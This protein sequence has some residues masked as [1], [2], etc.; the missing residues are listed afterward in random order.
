ML[1]LLLN[2]SDD[3]TAIVAC[4]LTVAGAALIVFASYHL[5]PAG[6]E[7]RSRRKGISNPIAGSEIPFEATQS[8]DRAA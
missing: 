7:L 6:Q 3:L 2:T 4:L 8:R 1:D 5:G